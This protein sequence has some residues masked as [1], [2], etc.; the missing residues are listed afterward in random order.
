MSVLLIDTGDIEVSTFELGY[1]RNFAL[2][3]I[4]LEADTKKLGGK[5]GEKTR[6]VTTMFR[7]ETL[8]VIV[9]RCQDN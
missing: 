5:A 8:P 6:N 3:V 4:Q 1:F 9:E 2:D 7:S